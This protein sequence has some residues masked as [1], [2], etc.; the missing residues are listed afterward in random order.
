MYKRQGK[1][2]LQEDLF[3]LYGFL[4][5]LQDMLSTKA[6]EK[7]LELL[8]EL[9]DDLPEIITADEGK[10]RQVL[11]NIIG[12]AIKFTSQGR[13]I[14]SVSNSKSSGKIKFA[15][16]DTGRGIAESEI[17]ALFEPFVQTTTGKK[18]IE[19]TGLGLPISREFVQLMGGE[20]SVSSQVEKGTTFTFEIIANIPEELT[21]I[22]SRE[23]LPNQSKIIE[24]TSNQYR[25]L[26]LIHI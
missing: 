3:D 17:E 4:Q 21:E 14:L 12:N 10:L 6:R 1:V 8:F 23:T 2:T 9:A 13:V 24:L 11:I 19:G 7:G 22:A 16:T 5:N 26:S 20:I 15:I 25:Y 18:T